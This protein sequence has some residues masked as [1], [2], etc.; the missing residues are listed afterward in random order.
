MPGW[1]APLPAMLLKGA[2]HSGTA[3][4]CCCHLLCKSNSAVCRHCCM[5]GAS[6]GGGAVAQPCCVAA[7]SHAKATV[8]SAVRLAWH[9]GTAARSCCVAA[10]CHA[11]QD[12][13]QYCVNG[14]SH[15]GG[16]VA[17]S[18]HVCCQMSCKSSSAV[19]CYCCMAQWHGGTVLLCGCHLSCN[20]TVRSAVTIA[21]RGGRVLLRGYHLSCKAGTCHAKQDCGLLSESMYSPQAQGT[22]AGSFLACLHACT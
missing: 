19:C 13:F 4:L 22:N 3:L 1:A 9:S 17:Q 10:F 8:R 18:G 16:T 21:W 6:H 12:C 20:A 7:T 15:N 5:N 2:L 11:K 14:A